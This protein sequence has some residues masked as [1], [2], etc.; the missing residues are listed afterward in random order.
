MRLVKLL[1]KLFT[2]QVLVLI[3]ISHFESN[4]AKKSIIE[5]QNLH[6]KKK[7]FKNWVLFITFSR[8]MT[9][10]FFSLAFCSHLQGMFS[11]TIRLLE[12]GIKPV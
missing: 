6:F 5:L 9:R 11:R 7:K 1:G 8:I 3:E 2:S 4:C 12:A 10:V